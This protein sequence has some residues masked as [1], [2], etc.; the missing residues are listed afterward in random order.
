MKNNTL[1][2]FFLGKE[3]AQIGKWNTS[4]ISMALND[5]EEGEDYIK[6]SNLVFLNKN[7]KVTNNIKKI[8]PLA[9]KLNDLIPETYIK[10]ELG[11]SLSSFK[12]YYDIIIISDVKFYKFKG[13]FKEIFSNITYILTDSEIREAISEDYIKGYIK[14]SKTKYLVWY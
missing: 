13:K 6:I 5:L 12:E 14:V 4:N 8:F 11:I 1:K 9:T 3:L 2:D 7:C 10:K